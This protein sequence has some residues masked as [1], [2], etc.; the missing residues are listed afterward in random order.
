MRLR[1]GPL[2][3]LLAPPHAV[4]DQHVSVVALV[5][6]ERVVRHGRVDSATVQGVAR[7]LTL[8]GYCA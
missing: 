5:G 7:K 3:V 4:S 6:D 1:S 8:D 2:L